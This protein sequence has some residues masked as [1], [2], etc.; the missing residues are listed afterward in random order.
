M[1]LNLLRASLVAQYGKESAWNAGETGLVPGAGRSPREGGNTTLVFLTWEIP[2]REEPGRPQPL[3]RNSWKQLSNYW[4]SPG[5]ACH[6]KC[7]GFLPLLWTQSKKLPVK[8]YR[9][10]YVFMRRLSYV[11]ANKRK[12]IIGMNLTH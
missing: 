4:L 3:G 7:K 2:W 8:E 1:S 9:I 10:W 12:S 6:R 5:S 11:S